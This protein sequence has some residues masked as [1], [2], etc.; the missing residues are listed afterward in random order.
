MNYILRFV[1]SFVLVGFAAA[2]SSYFAY[3]GIETFYP[4]L[5]TPPLTPPNM[6]FR[7]VWPILYVLMI[8][9]YYIILNHENHRNASLLFV[10]QLFLNVLWSFLFFANG[11]FLYGLVCIV[12][13]VLT[14]FAMIKKFHVLSHTAAYLQY[15]YLLWILFATYMTAGMVYLNGF[16]LKVM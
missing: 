6:V 10:G 13:L 1:V 3:Q 9:S 16:E 14:V 12:L 2:L 8:I 4:M 15:P 5:S 7:I 11:W